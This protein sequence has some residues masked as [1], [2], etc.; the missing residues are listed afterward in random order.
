MNEGTDP[1][2]F[3]DLG[4]LSRRTF[5]RGA[6]S[7]IAISLGGGLLS[8]CGSS[9]GAA[10]AKAGGA[11]TIQLGGYDN[12]IGAHEFANFAAQHPGSKVEQVVI[13]VDAERITKLATDPGAVDIMLL[14][15]SDVQRLVALGVVEDVDLAKV[16]NYRYVD[17]VFKVGYASTAQHKCV[18]TDYGKVG[19]AYRAD[20]VPERPTSW[21]DMWRLAATKYSGKVTL[22][23]YE[24]ETIPAVLKMLGY[25]A[26]SADPKEIQAAG[27]KLIEIK[28]HLQSFTSSNMASG[29]LNGSVVM[30]MDWD[31]DIYVAMQQNKNIVWVTPD[32]G[33]PAYIDTWVPINRSQHLDVVWEFFNFHFEPHNYAD[34]VN[35]TRTAF[36]EAAAR[37]YINHGIATSPVMYPPKSVLKR[38]EFLQGVGR[39][40]TVYDNVWQEV[41][42]A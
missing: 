12:W 22:L 42:A 8:A 4:L 15:V 38:V 26:S 13:N 33:S 30:A 37:P 2:T 18:A 23:D 3:S 1:S 16:P 31:Y 29:L 14:T 25:S 11:G 17:D 6:G 5:V 28:P 9:V 40:Q 35:T 20:L 7:A 21:A 32:E 39:A 41:K 24:M 10:D 27:Q 34:F 19:F 36:C